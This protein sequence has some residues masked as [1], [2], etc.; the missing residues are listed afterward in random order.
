MSNILGS[1][2]E[3]IQ[4]LNIL[5]IFILFSWNQFIDIKSSL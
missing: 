2:N 3:K 1:N 5:N 4:Q